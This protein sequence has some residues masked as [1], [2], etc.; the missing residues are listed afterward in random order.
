[1]LKRT[2]LVEKMG[3]TAFIK[4]A[5]ILESIGEQTP[6]QQPREPTAQPASQPT[7]KNKE[8]PKGQKAEATVQ[9]RRKEEGPKRSSFTGPGKANGRTT[10]HC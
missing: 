5:S 8:M 6:P 2:R 4:M 10:K 7:A 3:R 9:H 1:M